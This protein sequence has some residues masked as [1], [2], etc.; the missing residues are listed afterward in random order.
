[1]SSNDK[2]EPEIPVTPST[3]PIIQSL[4]ESTD[5]QPKTTIQ[6]L[7][8]ASAMAMVNQFQKIGNDSTNSPP[9]KK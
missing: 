9:T 2:S 8:M 4:Q 3:T 7:A 5:S 1:M 6:R